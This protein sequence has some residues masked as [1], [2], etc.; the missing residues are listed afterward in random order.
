MDVVGAGDGLTGGAALGEAGEHQ[1]RL[2][3]RECVWHHICSHVATQTAW[4]RAAIPVASVA[5]VWT[6][7]A[8]L[9][10]HRASHWTCARLRTG[11]RHCVR[12]RYCTLVACYAWRSAAAG[13]CDGCSSCVLAKKVTLHV[14]L[15]VARGYSG[16]TTC[17][18]LAFARHVSSPRVSRKVLSGFLTLVCIGS[19][20]RTTFVTWLVAP[21]P[22]LR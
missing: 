11:Y 17:R 4:T 2:Q 6:P 21:S 7:A 12:H 13:A 9:S 14:R 18:S 20:R 5:Y 1:E 19:S 8:T 10:P 15:L 3:E 22:A 16:T